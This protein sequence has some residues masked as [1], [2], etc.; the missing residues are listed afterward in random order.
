MTDN[1]IPAKILL[2]LAHSKTTG[3]EF[4][5]LSGSL[6]RQHLIFAEPRELRRNK[7]TLELS[8]IFRDRNSLKNWARNTE[9]KKY[10]LARFNTLLAEKP[11]TIKERDVIL[12]V[13]HVKNC[14]CGK[15][16][17]YILQ[18]RSL[19][20]INELTCSNCSGQVPYSKVPTEI[21]LE[22]W[23]VKYQRVYMNWLESG[24]F[25]KE[26]YKE[27]TNYKKGKLNLT[28]EKIRQQLSSYFKIP[29]YIRYFVAEEGSNCTCPVCKQ[30]GS[31]SG[32][33]RPN[34]ICKT[35]NTIFGYGSS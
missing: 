6:Y 30:K 21:Q 17:F 20:F 23:Q 15:P 27:L 24:L 19:Q 14:V 35:C 31:D 2:T 26:A 28:G 13:D 25:E 9:I 29:V 32:L 1:P 16:G 18:G 4:I 34:R 22:D 10:W 7:N 12:E 5:S 8:V 11:K 3:E 33:K